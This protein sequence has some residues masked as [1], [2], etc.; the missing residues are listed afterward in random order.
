MGS[1]FS[2]ILYIV[3]IISSTD[4]SIMIHY[5]FVMLTDY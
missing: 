5:H 1:A 4:D 2:I 3:N